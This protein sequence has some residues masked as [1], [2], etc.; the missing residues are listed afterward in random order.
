MLRFRTLITFMLLAATTEIQAQYVL[1]ALAEAHDTTI[2]EEATSIFK[3]TRLVNGHTVE[4]N[5]R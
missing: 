3:A 1:M 5:G 4:T 2:L